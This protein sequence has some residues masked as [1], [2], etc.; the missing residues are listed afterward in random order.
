MTNS[1]TTLENS[2]SY[3]TL[4][5]GATMDAGRGGTLLYDAIEAAA[6]ASL[7]RERGRR[8]DGDSDGRRR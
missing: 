7:G 2:L 1:V 3:L 5:H 4:P 6:K 8:G